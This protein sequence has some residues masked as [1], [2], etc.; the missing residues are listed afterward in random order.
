MGVFKLT[1]GYDIPL[2]GEAERRT[3]R[4]A[5]QV[6]GSSQRPV[7]E[8]L[9]AERLVRDPDAPAARSAAGGEALDAR[10]GEG[11]ER[12]LGPGGSGR[13]K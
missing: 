9:E 8:I 12:A 3:G 4:V 6:D 7:V 13:R 10:A 2:Q 11:G 5:R 1:R